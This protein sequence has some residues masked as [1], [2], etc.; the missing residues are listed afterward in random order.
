MDI[1]DLQSVSGKLSRITCPC[2][3]YFNAVETSL[4]EESKFGC[5]RLNCCVE[6]M[7]CQ[8]CKQRINFKLKAPDMETGE[9][10]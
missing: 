2:G 3:G 10:E 6:T 8:K 1:H 9:R 5:G 7:E 4:E